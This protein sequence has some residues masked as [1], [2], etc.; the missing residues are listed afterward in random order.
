MRSAYLLVGTLALAAFA[1]CS[2]SSSDNGG[3]SGS[4][5]PTGDPTI[6]INNPTN[7]ATIAES[8][9]T[10]GADLDV[11]YTTTNFTLKSPNTCAGAKNCGHVHVYVDGDNCNDVGLPANAEDVTNPI[12]A[13]LDYCKSGIPGAHVVKLELH[14]DDHSVTKNAA[15]NPVSDQINITVTGDATDGGTDS[16]TDSGGGG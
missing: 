8:S 9:L 12:S 11:A 14:N 15:G 6:K 10:D 4:D 2:S 3:D 13:G 5:T 7:N 16:A 1:A